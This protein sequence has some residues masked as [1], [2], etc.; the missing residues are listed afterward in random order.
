M[1]VPLGF[2]F[3][4]IHAGIKPQRKDVALVYS[5]TPCSAAGCFT[6]NKAQAAPVQDAEP[7]LPAS[8]IQAVLVNS[9]QRQRPHRPRRAGRPCAPCWPSWAAPSPCPPSAV[10]TASTGVIGHPA[11]R[12]QDGRR[13]CGALKDS[14]RSEP[15]A[16]AEAIMTTDTRAKQ[17]W[18]S[19]RIG[20]RDVTLSAICKGSGMMHPS[21]ATMIA[22]I[23]TDCAIQPGVLAA[24]L[25]EAVSTTFNSLTVDGDMSTNDAVFALANGRA[26]NPPSRPGPELTIFT[27]TLTDLC[28]EMARE[29]AAD[30]EGATKLLEV[31]VTGAPDAAI[32]QDLARAVAGSTLVK[33]AVFGADPNWGRVLATVGARAGTQGYAVDPYSARV[34][35]QGICVYDGEPRPHDPAHLKTRMREPEVRIEVRPHRRR[36]LVRGVGLRS[37]VRL[38]EDQRGLHLAHRPQARRRRGQGRPAGQLQPRVQDDAARRGAL[39]HLPLPRQ[40]LR[41]P[42]RRRGHG[43]GVPQAGL[44]PGHRAAAL[45]G[46][47]AHHRARRRAGAHPHAGQARPAP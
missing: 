45:G 8:G 21:L 39:V 14:L 29:I 38:R 26:G 7:R 10:L 16:A 19:V 18:R 31:E 34:R 24:A 20:G 4:G 33:A 2:S 30:G 41:H 6:A 3:S 43:E 32:A 28:L 47:S 5:D 17:A 25:R 36:G 23:T 13:C 35:I 22:V 1:K 12:A 15:D 11:A 27:A 46:P 40:A 9:R 42:L 44:L 37:L